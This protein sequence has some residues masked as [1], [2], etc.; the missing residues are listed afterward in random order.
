[1]QSF[2][3]WNKLINSNIIEIANEIIPKAEMYEYGR[4]K[5]SKNLNNLYWE[6]FFEAINKAINEY[7][8][9]PQ[10]ASG[11]PKNCE[12]IVFATESQSINWLIV[13]KLFG[14]FSRKFA[15]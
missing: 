7:N 10:K 11:T 12:S 5:T 9:S 4:L 3:I 6:S 1:M 2:L 13:Q 15:L 8:N 14:A